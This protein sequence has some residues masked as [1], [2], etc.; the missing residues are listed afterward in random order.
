MFIILPTILLSPPF[1]NYE[2]NNVIGM[3]KKKKKKLINNPLQ[4]WIDVIN[5]LDTHVGDEPENLN[6]DPKSGK[7]IVMRLNPNYDAK[8]NLIQLMKELKLKKKIS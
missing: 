4:K 5:S 2:N 7:D 6:I 8:K 3:S 1:N